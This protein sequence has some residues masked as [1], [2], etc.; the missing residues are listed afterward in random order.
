MWTQLVDSGTHLK[1]RSIDISKNP[2]KV[3]PSQ[4]SLMINLKSLNA[5]HSEIQRITCDMTPLEKLHQVDLSHN[6]L[7]VDSLNPLSLSIQ[8]LNLSSNH[9]VKVPVALFALSS[10][11]ELDLSNNR[12]ESTEG[13]GSIISLVF[14]NLD[15]NQI[16]EV[17]VDMCNLIHLQKISL[18]HNLIR[19]YTINY[20]NNYE[21]SI[22]EAFFSNL[23][24]D[25]INLTG[26]PLTNAEVNE[27]KGVDSF[28]KR[29]QK[30]REKAALGGALSNFNVFGLQWNFT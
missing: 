10:L 3:L 15:N 11:T 21:Q 17:T 8:K 30:Q 2:L 22:P 6:D 29:N 4:L 13:L 26:N 24:V 27:F 7:D 20:D 16:C 9:F 23:S 18:A 25:T 12:I 14:L 1:L 5:S 28:L 19:K